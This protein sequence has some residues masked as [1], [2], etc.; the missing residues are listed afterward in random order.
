MCAQEW[1]KKNLGYQIVCLFGHSEGCPIFSIFVA[2]FGN[3]LQKKKKK[4][5]K[6]EHSQKQRFVSSLIGII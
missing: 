2:G 5:I 4:K 3:I 1:G 6:I